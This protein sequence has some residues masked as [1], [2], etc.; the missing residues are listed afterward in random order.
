MK[1]TK[2][3]DLF[4]NPEVDDYHDEDAEYLKENND[5]E[6]DSEEKSIEEDE[7]EE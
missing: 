1:P 7:Y 5:E 3:Q 2:V 4:D 6:V